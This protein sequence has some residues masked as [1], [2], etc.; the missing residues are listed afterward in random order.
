MRD[1]AV[2]SFRSFLGTRGAYLGLAF[3]LLP[4]GAMCLGLALQSN[5]AVELGLN[6]S[7]VATLNL[8]SGIIQAGFMVVGGFLSDR[9]GRRRMLALYIVLMSVPV[10]YLMQVLQQHGWVMPQSSSNRTVA[11][12]LLITALWVAT[13]TYGVALGLM[14]GT[15][16]AIFMDVTNPRVAATQF[17]AYM[18]LLNLNIA[19]SATWQGIA[20]EAIGYPKTMLIDAIFGLAC[21]LLLPWIRTV[22][23]NEPDGG[24]PLRARISAVVLGL[25]CLAWVPYRLEQAA[26]GAAAPIF[27]TVFTVA[28]VASALFLLAGAAVLKDAPRA[29]VRAG[30]WMALLLLL[31]YARRWAGA[32]GAPLAGVANGVI[33]AVPVVA[34]LLLLAL[35]AQRWRELGG[36][37]AVGGGAAVPQTSAS[38]R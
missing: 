33:L 38:I 16:S 18:A 34:G 20:I 5:L 10:L 27:E 37:T 29:L 14:Y 15:R 23:G 4:S 31:M 6:D 21:L 3:A 2:E 28:F 19:Y 7:E 30:A 35:A 12:A 17:T 26:L 8:W 36:A 32:P 1:F 22:R 24:A 9:F 11:P 25:A 13:L